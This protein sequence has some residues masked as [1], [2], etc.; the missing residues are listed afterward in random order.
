MLQ[1]VASNDM[2]KAYLEIITRAS[3]RI[4]GLINDLVRQ[5]QPE[6]LHTTRYSIPALLDEIILMT[7]D[8]LLIKNITLTKMYTSRDYTKRGDRAAMKIA[9][10]NIIINAIDAMKIEKGHLKLFSHYQGGKYIIQIMDNGCGISEGNLKHIFQPYFTSKK[11]GLG[12]GL[13]A[14]HDILKKNK[15]GIQVTSQPGI[16]TKF[17]LSF[18]RECL[19][20][21]V[22]NVK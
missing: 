13:S 1:A 3:L 5:E 7:A 21:P 11:D 6:H 17:T 10:T 19:V 18:P 12:I 14:T 4:N 9:L 8:R 20:F 2:Q 15:V 22:K 16:G